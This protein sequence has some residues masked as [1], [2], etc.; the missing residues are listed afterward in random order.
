MYEKRDNPLNS[1]RMLFGVANCRRAVEIIEGI[2]LPQI[3]AA[4]QYWAKVLK[5]IEDP[6][7]RDRVDMAAG[8]LA[9]TY[10]GLGFCGGWLGCI[11]ED[12]LI[13]KD[14]EEIGITRSSTNGVASPPASLRM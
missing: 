13:R 7:L 3:T 5:E 11:E 10:Q 9:W 4:E 8:K 14:R 2:K 1:P 6:D 12:E